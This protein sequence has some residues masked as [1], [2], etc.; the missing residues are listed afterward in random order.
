MTE[1]ETRFKLCALVKKSINDNQSQ[2]SVL[3]QISQKSIDRA[4]K[5]HF[6][7]LRKYF[8]E[9]HSNDIRRIY[10]EHPDDIKYICELHYYL[11]QFLTIEKSSSRDYQTGKNIPCLVFTKIINREKIKIIKLNI[12]RKKVLKL[13]TLYRKL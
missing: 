6:I 8:C 13:K 4:W 12:S 9:V 5:K 1:E 10:K 3:F 11:E 7:D 2:D